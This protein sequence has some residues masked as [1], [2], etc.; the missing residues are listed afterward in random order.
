MGG[1]WDDRNT[2]RGFRKKKQMQV[3]QTKKNP[4]AGVACLVYVTAEG[5]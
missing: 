4:D 5:V 1:N 2:W 3:I